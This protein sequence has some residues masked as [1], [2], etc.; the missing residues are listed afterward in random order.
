MRHVGEGT[1][2]TE[3]V[4]AQCIKTRQGYHWHYYDGHFHHVPKDW[5]FPHIGV[6]DAWK[7]WWIGDSVRGIPPLRMLDSKDLEFLDAIPLTEEEQHGWTGPNK[8]RC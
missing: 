3:A 7:Q 1:E 4:D 8:N 2:N 5:H 6:L